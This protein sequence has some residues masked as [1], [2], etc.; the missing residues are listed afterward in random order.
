MIAG[1][2]LRFQ[3]SEDNYQKRTLIANAPVCR[4]MVTHSPRRSSIRAADDVHSGYADVHFRYAHPLT[5]PGVKTVGYGRAGAFIRTS[6]PRDIEQVRGGDD[7]LA[8]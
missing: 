4:A 1:Q 5:G 7:P 2:W 8:D 3:A 6:L